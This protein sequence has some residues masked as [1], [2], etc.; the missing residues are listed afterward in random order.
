MRYRQLACGL[1]VALACGVVAASPIPG[2]TLTDEQK[3]SLELPRTWELKDIA[4]EAPPYGAEGKVY[5]L[6][7]L[8]KEDDRPLRVES[9]LVLKDLGKDDEHGRWCLS[10]L[11]RHPDGRDNAW[12]L[13]PLWVSPPPP[14]GPKEPVAIDHAKRLKKKPTNKDVYEAAKDVQWRFAVDEGWKLL[15]CAVCERNWFAAVGEKPTRFFG[16]K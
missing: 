14:L 10:H 2:D 13:P 12:T 3:R 1:A 6:A 15:S 11:Y 4:A 16:G 7:W 5:V 8:I 9:C